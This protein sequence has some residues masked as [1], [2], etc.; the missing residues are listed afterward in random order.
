[1][2]NRQPVGL[3]INVSSF[4]NTNKEEVDF[5]FFDYNSL[6]S[7]ENN[8]NEQNF[9]VNNAC[10]PTQFVTEVVIETKRN[11]LPPQEV[12]FVEDTKSLNCNNLENS[13]K[14]LNLPELNSNCDLSLVNCI[15]YEE[16][17]D[18]EFEDDADSFE[19]LSDSTNT[20]DL[21][22]VTP[23]SSSNGSINMIKQII[24]VEQTEKQSVINDSEGEIVEKG[25]DVSESGE[26]E[27]SSLVKSLETLSIPDSSIFS[28][29]TSSYSGKSKPKRK[30]MTF[31]NE[32]LRQINR[33]N[34]ILLKKIMAHAKPRPKQTSTIHNFHPTRTSAAINRLKQQKQ[35]E[36]DNYVSINLSKYIAFKYIVMN[37]FNY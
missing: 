6:R 12:S 33:D 27:M 1:M 2:S 16:Y 5:D 25:S 21:T 14:E 7:D 35:I 3:N 10:R 32:Q 8:V 37:V 18:E 15:A 19:S 13:N 22:T 36:H 23:I 11:G 31:T 30:S 9:E 26:K 20:S 34:D 4:D 29:V 24:P 28:R 17:S